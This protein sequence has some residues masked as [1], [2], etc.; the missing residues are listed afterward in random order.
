MQNRKIALVIDDSETNRTIFSSFLKERGYQ[1]VCVNDGEAGLAKFK[2][3]NP[4]LTFLDIIMPKKSGLDLL[5]EIKTIN[6][7][8]IV[9]MVSSYV[10]KQTISQA[11]HDHADWFLMKPVSKEKFYA[12]M[13]KFEKK[14]ETVS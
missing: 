6:P 10:S 7:N 9:V 13:D 5:K 14:Q 8:A 11:K 1:A 4:F 2:E 12:V 3:I